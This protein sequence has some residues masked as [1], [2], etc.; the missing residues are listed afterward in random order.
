MVEVSHS[1]VPALSSTAAAPQSPNNSGGL[2]NDTSTIGNATITNNSVLNFNG[3]STTG[4]ASIINGDS[5]TMSFNARRHDRRRS[6]ARSAVVKTPKRTLSG[7]CVRR[8][9]DVK[10]RGGATQ[11]IASVLIYH[12]WLGF[13]YSPTSFRENPNCAIAA[14]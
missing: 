3:N 9:T 13:G 10:Q 14:S 12:A 6:C 4:N 8:E 7:R 2:L 11:F 1:T 5:D